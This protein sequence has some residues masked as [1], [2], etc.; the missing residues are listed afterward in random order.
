M[1]EIRQVYEVNGQKFDTKAEAQDFLR[2]P[3]IRTALLAV[4]A[5]KTELTEWLIDNSETVETAFEVGTI[6]R[7]TKS[8]KKKLEKA[9]DALVEGYAHEPKLAFLVENAG[10]IK[11]TFRWPSVTRMKDEEKAK[12]AREALVAATEGREDVADWIIA[13]KDAILAAY[14]AGIEKREVSTAATEGLNAYRAKKAAE[15]A[16]KAAAAT[17]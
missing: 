12:A 3:K 16:A 15:K 7:V 4:T 5:G 10:A 9:L 6:K 14:A 17:A 1:S 8:E 13:N 2:K 11:E